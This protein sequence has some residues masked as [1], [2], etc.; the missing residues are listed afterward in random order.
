MD[1][2]D[3]CIMDKFGLQAP[4]IPYVK[5]GRLADTGHMNLHVQTL[6]EEYTKMLGR[7]TK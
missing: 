3:K 4:N 2:M 7:V 5:R 1:Y 6:V